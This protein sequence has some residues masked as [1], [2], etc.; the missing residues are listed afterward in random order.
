M[1][2]D[3]AALQAG[4]DTG[5]QATNEQLKPIVDTDEARRVLIALDPSHAVPHKPPILKTKPG[6]PLT[7]PSYHGSAGEFFQQSAY[8][9]KAA[10]KVTVSIP[11][12]ASEPGEPQRS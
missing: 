10:R 9:R 3:A 4:Q 11:A 6:A 5:I 12:V 1:R 2:G 7:A 8:G